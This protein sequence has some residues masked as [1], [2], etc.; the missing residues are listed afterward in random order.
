MYIYKT[1]Q[2]K[3]IWNATMGTQ[4]IEHMTLQDDFCGQTGRKFI[5]MT[6]FVD[7]QGYL[8]PYHWTA[9]VVRMDQKVLQFTTTYLSLRK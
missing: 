5:L 4:C 2:C 6:S 7:L 9:R 1:S 8:F 3:L